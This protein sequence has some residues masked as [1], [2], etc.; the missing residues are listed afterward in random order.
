V[1]NV[2]IVS[3]LKSPKSMAESSQFPCF[4]RWFA[5]IAVACANITTPPFE[6]RAAGISDE[7]CPGAVEVFRCEFNG[8]A[9]PKQVGWPDHWTRERG[10]GYPRYLEVRIDDAAPAATNGRSLRMNLDGG[11]AAAYSPAI[12]VQPQF[13]YVF[14]CLVQTEGLVHNRAFLSVTFYDAQNKV[15]ERQ[16]STGM[17]STTAW[18]KLQIGP[19]APASDAIDHAIIGLHLEPTTQADLQGSAWFADVWAGRLPR[20]KLEADHRNRLYVDPQRPTITYTAS[21]F[22]NRDAAV[23]FVMVDVDG[24]D[25]AREQVPVILDGPSALPALS[26]HAIWKPP[27]TDVGLY[28][29]RATLNGRADSQQQ[30]EIALVLIHDQ[31]LAPRGEFGW[32]LRAA[33]KRLTLNELAELAHH[34]GINW[35]K[36]PIWD[37]SADSQHVEQL[38]SFAD[39]LRNENVEL[40]GVLADPPAEVRKR[41]H[42]D[43]PISAAQVFL[44]EPDVWYPSVEPI[45]TRLSQIVRTWQLGADDDLS[46]VNHPALPAMIDRVRQQMERFGQPAKL[47]FAWS[48]MQSLPADVPGWNFVSLADQPSVSAQ[49]EAEFLQKTEKAK[50]RRY[51]P[52]QPLPAGEFSL[53]DRAADLSQR[54]MAAKI[55]HADRIFIPQILSSSRGLCDEN[56]AVGDLFLPWR[57]TAQ[58]LAGTQFEGSL[59]LPG[60]SSNRV[61]SRDQQ[62]VMMAWNDKPCDEKVNLGIE[63]RQVDLWGRTVKLAVDSQRQQHAKVGQLPIFLTDLNEPLLRWQMSASLA[64][65][66]WPSV[67]GLPY[68]NAVTITSSFSQTVAGMVQLIAPDRWRVVPREISFKLAPGET[69]QFPLEVTLPFD[70]MNGSQEVRLDFD[71]SAERRYK[72]SVYRTI[73]IGLDDVTLDVATRLSEQ[74]ELVVEQKLINKT[75][76]PVSFRCS[77]FVPDRQ[78][79]ITQVVDQARGAD[80]QTYRLPRG[81]ELIGKTIWLRADELT[82][83]RTLNTRFQVK[84]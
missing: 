29:V 73:D 18:T 41:F 49:D 48:W 75:D 33:E 69:R 34:A 83:R 58:Q 65:T 5:V 26:G 46:F 9:D 81:S 50:I 80:V 38:Y 54:M 30:R 59:R 62:L 11:A 8:A 17:G 16:V 28:R 15:L 12:S 1:P 52:L 20:M 47:G 60:G 22:E 3:G 56:G 14:Q 55:A 27:L 19:V 23:D 7:R 70:T 2:M 57:T 25:V 36:Y 53:M 71:I 43:G 66:K 4:C 51:V 32:S 76:D 67:F 35:L 77:L 10:A 82:G 37:E 13:S 40:V 72:F 6:L 44:A 61:F 74:G 42:D 24:H 63:A 45:C 39:G 64:E 78:R 31:K 79:M 68:T 21:G 84:P